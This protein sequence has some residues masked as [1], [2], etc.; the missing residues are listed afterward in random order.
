MILPLSVRITSDFLLQ[1]A[2][3]DA[4]CFNISSFEILKGVEMYWLNAPIQ[5]NF[6]YIKHFDLYS[7]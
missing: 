5:S 7:I 2:S 1:A 6:I 3:K 4:N